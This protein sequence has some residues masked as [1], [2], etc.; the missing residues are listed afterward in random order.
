VGGG[1]SRCS[2]GSTPS[3][4]KR[5]GT[6]WHPRRSSLLVAERGGGEPPHA[7]REPRDPVGIRLNRDEKN[8]RECG[9]QNGTTADD[10]HGEH[11]E[12]P[13]NKEERAEETGLDAEL[14]VVGLARFQ[15]H[16]LAERDL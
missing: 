4:G 6:T 7:V 8:G 2:H 16:T 15:R 14:R 5:Q 1:S 12:V 13:H 3:C 11:A 9:G 10:E